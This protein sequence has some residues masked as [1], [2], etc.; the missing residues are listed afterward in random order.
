[1]T[2][3][4][5]RIGEFAGGLLGVDLGA[6]EADLEYPASGGNEFDRRDLLLET[7]KE[8]RQTDGFGLIV[9]HRA[10]LDGNLG[11]HKLLAAS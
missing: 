3:D 5:L 7:Q 10:V 9:S 8:F 1:L 2:Q 6:V 4:F 11:L